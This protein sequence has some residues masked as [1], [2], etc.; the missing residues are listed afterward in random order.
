MI[1]C[2]FHYS[3]F[4]SYVA[5]HILLLPINIWL[6]PSFKFILICCK[7]YIVIACSTFCCFYCSCFYSHLVNTLL[8]WNSITLLPIVHKCILEFCVVFFYT[9]N[10]LEL[11][12]M[13]GK[14]GQIVKMFFAHMVYILEQASRCVKVNV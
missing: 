13:C 8:L 2:C 11:W 9:T 1:C 6:H 7:P 5:N 12:G 10:L 4:F 14:E 3:C